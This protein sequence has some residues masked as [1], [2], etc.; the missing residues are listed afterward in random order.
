MSVH[1]VNWARL[2]RERGREVNESEMQGIGVGGA[3]RE[4]DS[5]HGDLGEDERRDAIG[6][7]AHVQVR[8]GERAHP[9]LRDDDIAGFRGDL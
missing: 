2:P 5:G 8:T 7:E 4:Y 6:G 3:R 9:V 1:R